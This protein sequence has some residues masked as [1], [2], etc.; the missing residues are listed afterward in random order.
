MFSDLLCVV[1][2]GSEY[3]LFLKCTHVWKTMI[4]FIYVQKNYWWFNMR[5]F[6][7]GILNDIHTLKLYCRVSVF[8][9]LQKSIELIFRVLFFTLT[10]SPCSPWRTHWHDRTGSTIVSTDYSSEL[11]WKRNRW[12][13]MYYRICRSHLSHKYKFIT[14]CLTACGLLNCASAS[15]QV[16]LMDKW[17]TVNSSSV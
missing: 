11:S 9:I 13:Y 17:P 14:P 4:C 1:G 7:I 16:S 2:W 5:C 8:H 3:S 12:R 10:A 6:N 15:H